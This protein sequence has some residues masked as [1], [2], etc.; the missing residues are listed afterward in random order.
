MPDAQSTDQHLSFKKHASQNPETPTNSENLSCGDITA[1]LCYEFPLF[2]PRIPANYIMLIFQKT[3]NV[4]LVQFPIALILLPL[5][6]F[7][8]DT[9]S[10]YMIW[11]LIL[12]CKKASYLAVLTVESLS[13]MLALRTLPQKPVEDKQ[14]ISLNVI[15]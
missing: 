6:H 1:F 2:L 10:V 12:F 4:F 13:A 15:N 8:N 14:L 9:F 11:M 7:C 5:E 3:W